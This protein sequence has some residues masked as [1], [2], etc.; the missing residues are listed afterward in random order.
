MA[1]QIRNTSGLKP[2]KKGQSG[3]PGG[4]SSETARLIRDNADAAARIRAKLLSATEETLDSDA[5]DAIMKRIDAAM[6]KLLTDSETRGMG[7]PV[8][9]IDNTSSDGS[10]S[11]RAA[12]MTDEQ[13]ARIA[14]G[15]DD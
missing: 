8:Q 1:E 12:E 11:P 2:F 15:D 7:A 4:M 10:M 5:T 13:L 14:S 3:N 9:Q 6:L